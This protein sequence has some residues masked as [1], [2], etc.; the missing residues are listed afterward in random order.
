MSL[1][2]IDAVVVDIDGTITDNDRRISIQAMEA[3]RETESRGIPVMIATGGVLCFAKTVSETIGLS[4]PIIAEN[5]GLVHQKIKTQAKTEILGNKEECEKAFAYLSS[6]L[7]VK[8]TDVD[9]F[10]ITEIAIYPTVDYELVKQIVSGYDVRV[11]DTG[12]AYHIT[13]SGIN[14]G[15]GLEKACSMLSIKPSNVAAI[16]DSENDIELFEKAGIGI[17]VGNAAEKLRKRAE[18]V[19]AA[20]HGHGVVEALVWLGII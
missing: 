4:G 6:Q 9:E 1:P 13:S 3:L 14:K 7:E 8:K 12:F 20:N 11:F 10:R 15:L 2:E 16:G 18:H 17:A 5:G 19:V